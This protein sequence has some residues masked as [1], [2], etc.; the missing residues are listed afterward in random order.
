[1]YLK[2]VC[3]HSVSQVCYHQTHNIQFSQS[4][5]LVN[6]LQLGKDMEG[7]DYSVR[8]CKIIS[9]IPTPPAEIS[10]TNRSCTALSVEKTNSANGFD[11]SRMMLIASSTPLTYTITTRDHMARRIFSKCRE[12]P[13]L[14]PENKVPTLYSHNHVSKNLWVQVELS[15]YL[16]L[17]EIGR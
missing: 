1:M 3:G 14:E 16:R 10:V 9:L 4:T 6:L 2:R 15:R 7:M 8:T 17:K 5:S 12:D 11:S 13:N